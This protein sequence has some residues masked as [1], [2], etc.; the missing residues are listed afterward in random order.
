MSVH[1]DL[2]IA[3]D[4]KL[5]TPQRAIDTIRWLQSADQA[6]D[7]AS[8]DPL[9]QAEPTEPTW[10]GILQTTNALMVRFP[11]ETFSALRRA[12]R[13]NLPETKG[14]GEVFYYTFSFRS[15]ILDDALGD[16]FVFLEWLAAY[17]HTQGFV[18]YMY[19]DIDDHPTLIYFREGRLSLSDTTS[20]FDQPK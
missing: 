10:K 14:G 13:Y 16:Y 9:F 17:S 8:I 20:L 7:E 5:D 19:S 11:G 2:Y 12:Y 6:I 18:G 4:L 15:E 3:C 1:F